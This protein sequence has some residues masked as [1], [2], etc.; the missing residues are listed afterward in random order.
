MADEMAQYQLGELLL[1]FEGRL[2][3][4]FDQIDDRFNQVDQRLDGLRN[5]QH[6]LEAAIASV[7]TRLPARIEELSHRMAELSHSMTV[8]FEKGHANMKLGLEAVQIL[9][10]RMDR[11]FDEQDARRQ[12]QIDLLKAV[13]RR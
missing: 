11:R 9:E 7:D 10:E 5:G 12:E 8:Q 6:S 1:E 4:R 3:Q 2:N 13:A